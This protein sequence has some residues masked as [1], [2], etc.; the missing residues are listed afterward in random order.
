MSNKKGFTLIEILVAIAIVGI[1]ATVVIVNLSS[2]RTRARGAKISGSLSSLIPS[3]ATCWSFSGSVYAPSESHDI[4]SL[5]SSYGQWPAISG[6]GYYYGEASAASLP[7]ELQ[8]ESPSNY[9]FSFF[10][11][12][13]KAAVLGP[14]YLSK[15]NWYFSAANDTDKNKICCNSTMKGCKVIDYTATCDLNTN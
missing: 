7:N 6:D 5:S 2:Y 9:F 11:P 13:V 15:T 8:P 4:C 3:M 14:S 10:I 12:V 1:L